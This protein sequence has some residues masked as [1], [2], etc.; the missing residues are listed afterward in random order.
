[1]MKQR[2]QEKER[3]Q[4]EQERFQQE[5]QLSE[6]QNEQYHQQQQGKI[7]DFI[8]KFIDSYERPPQHTEI[9]AAL[10]LDIDSTI[11]EDYLKAYDHKTY[12]PVD[13]LNNV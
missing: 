10:T 4:Q 1:M 7:V 11:L 12:K 3:L 13:P 6:K 2:Q 9:I 5:I 8:R